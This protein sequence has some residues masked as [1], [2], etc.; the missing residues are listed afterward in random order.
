MRKNM[1]CNEWG[2]KWG[3]VDGGGYRTIKK[4]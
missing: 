1:L 4:K 2:K 3:S